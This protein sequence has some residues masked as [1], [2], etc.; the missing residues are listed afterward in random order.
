MTS[1]VEYSD[2]MVKLDISKTNIGF[3]LSWEVELPEQ[4]MNPFLKIQSMPKLK[5]FNCQHAKQSSREIENL[6]KLMPQIRINQEVFGRD[7]ACPNESIDPED[8]LWDIFIKT[9]NLFP[10]W[11]RGRN[12]VSK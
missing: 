3:G 11:T 2:Q 10:F 7:I 8:G 12:V 9:I 6:R 1:I 5:V 4:G